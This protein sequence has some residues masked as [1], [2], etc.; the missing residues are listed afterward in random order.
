MPAAAIRVAGR[1]ASD[2]YEIYTRCSRESAA[3]MAMVI[4]S[5]RFEDLERGEMFVNEEL[6]LTAAE[7]PALAASA[8]VEQELIDDAI[9]D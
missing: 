3:R 1:W 9:G 6:M 4:G 2:I 8:F 7:R 5:T